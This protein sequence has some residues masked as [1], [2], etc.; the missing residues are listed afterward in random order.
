[1]DNWEILKEEGYYDRYYKIKRFNNTDYKV[2]I[3]VE[4]LTKSIKMW[5]GASSG[6]KRKQIDSYQVDDVIRLGGVSALLWIKSE[7]F[8]FPKYYENKYKT[9]KKIYLCIEWSDNRRRDIYSRSLLKEGFRF[10]MQDNKKILMK[11]I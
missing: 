3:M 2:D 10:S 4:D 8:S 5:I 6:S 7:I 11:K 9:N 1:M